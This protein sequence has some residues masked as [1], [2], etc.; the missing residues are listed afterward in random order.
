MRP[1]LPAAALALLAACAPPP[2]PP[3]PA[4]APV[5]VT[6]ASSEAY[7]K[8]T[9]A[10]RLVMEDGDR[11]GSI[12]RVR[13]ALALDPEF[14]MAWRLLAVNFNA[15]GRVGE[16]R[17]A[18]QKAL[19]YSSH[20][21]ATEQLHIAAVHAQYS[22]YNLQESIRL[23]GELLMQSPNDRLAHYNRALALRRLGAYDD[24]LIHLD[25]FRE[26]SPQGMSRPAARVR[27][28]TLVSLGRIEEAETFLPNL[29]D[30]DRRVGAMRLAMARRDW[31]I[32][33]S[34]GVATGREHSSTPWW[35][36]VVASARAARGAVRAADST[37]HISTTGSW[38][39]HRL[40]LALA[41]E[42]V[43]AVR[44]SSW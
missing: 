10:R 36:V 30:V 43:N 33:E 14:A 7:E 27:F 24:A 26:L 44:M 38:Q 13:E 8:Y 23:Y 15:Q 18:L 16:S 28:R 41:T 11:R 29:L 39:Q 25:R 5:E 1:L 4:P 19:E 34:L 22:D 6:T 32:A 20:V 2:E 35:R 31:A 9:E 12:A 42:C 40:I 17:H 21:S 3:T 37:L